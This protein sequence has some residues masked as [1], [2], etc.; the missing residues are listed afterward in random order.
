MTLKLFARG[1]IGVC[2]RGRSILKC[3]IA[4]VVKKHSVGT[5]SDMAAAVHEATT[6]YN[7]DVNEAGERPAQAALGKQPRM[8]GFVRTG[9][10]RCSA[11]SC[12]PP[13]PA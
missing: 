13:C 3:L 1:K 2:E 6:A 7:H 11:A 8:V 9:P 10:H 12:S 4:T 5:F